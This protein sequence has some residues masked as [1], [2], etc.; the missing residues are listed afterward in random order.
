MT[1]ETK[2]HTQVPQV[3]VVARGEAR[4]QGPPPGE[5]APPRRDQVLTSR[6]YSTGTP[7]AAHGLPGFLH[8]ERLMLREPRS[9]DAKELFEDCTRDSQVM[10]YL[11]WRPH[12]SVAD[13]EQFIAGCVRDWT[14]GIKLPYVVALRDTPDHAIGMLEARPRSHLIEIGY[15]LG[16]AH[17][18]HGFMAEAL[19]AW[20]D[21]A[22]GSP[23]I[24]RVQA[25]CDVDNVGSARVLDKAGF[26]REGRLER[27]TVYPNI[28]SEPRPCFLYGLTR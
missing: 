23:S 13:T 20:A 6:L 17:W 22:L 26:R 19:K 8:T 10:R 12:A 11:P 3:P 2:L 21:A 27:S 24:F 18:G 16:R 28:D 14:N 9:S 4:E 25:T 5:Y 7:T 1:N 15:M